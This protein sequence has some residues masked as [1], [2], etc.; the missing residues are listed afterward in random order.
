MQIT[1]K[2]FKSIVF[3]NLWISLSAAGLTLNTFFYLQEPINYKLIAFVFFATFTTYNLQRIIKHYYKKQNYNTRHQWFYRNHLLI[4]VLVLITCLISLFLG[5]YLFTFSDF[6]YLIPFGF[7][8]LF[9]AISLFPNKKSL[10]DLPFLKIFLIATTWS[11]SA[12]ILPL[13]T[14]NIKFNFHLFTLTSIIC[15]YIISITIPFD[16]RDIDLDDNTTKTIPQ[17]LG[18]ETSINLASLLLIVAAGLCLLIK[19]NLFLI[20][21]LIALVVVQLSR[22]EKP[23]LFYSGL[24][25]G[26]ILTFPLVGYFLS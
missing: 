8:S 16:I 11:F 3:S 18:V 14:L 13:I 19:T 20:P 26:I 15:I 9:Y 12:V 6:I 10:R 4:S 5:L 7:A 21:V 24:I 25:D 23:E 17:V 1:I 22:K 2:L